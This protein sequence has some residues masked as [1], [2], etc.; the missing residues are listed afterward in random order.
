VVSRERFANGLRICGIDQDE[1]QEYAGRFLSYLGGRRVV[2]RSLEDAQQF[3]FIGCDFYQGPGQN[4]DVVIWDLH[5]S[6]ERDRGAIFAQLKANLV[7]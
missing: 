5:Q 3:R 7:D 6:D 1:Q 4:D 2:V